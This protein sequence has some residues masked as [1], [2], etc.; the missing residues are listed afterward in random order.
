MTSKS[1][2]ADRRSYPVPLAQLCHSQYHHGVATS[3]NVDHALLHHVL[4]QGVKGHAT[5]APTVPVP[6]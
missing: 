4:A 2:R 5:H 1:F 6:E 3:F